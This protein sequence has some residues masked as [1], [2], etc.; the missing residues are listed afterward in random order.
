MPLYDRKGIQP[1]KSI[2]QQCI[3]IPIWETNQT[4]ALEK[5][6]STKD[7]NKDWKQ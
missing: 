7:Y 6:E 2:S 5:Q 1:I 3:K 4:L